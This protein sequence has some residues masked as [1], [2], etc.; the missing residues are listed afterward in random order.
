MADIFFAGAVT[1]L[2]GFWLGFFTAAFFAG[3]KEHH[4]E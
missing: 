4:D 3:V 2:I 1:A